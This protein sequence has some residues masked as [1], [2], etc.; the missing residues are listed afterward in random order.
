[1]AVKASTTAARKGRKGVGR[2]SG[3]PQDAVFV[4]W[5]HPTRWH[6]WRIQAI[7]AGPRAF[8]LPTIMLRGRDWAKSIRG[9]RVLSEGD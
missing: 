8:S 6:D 2:R 3:E 4:A 5:E 9:P 1:M 7:I